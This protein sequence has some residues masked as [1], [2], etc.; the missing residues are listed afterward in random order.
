MTLQKTK[1]K[2]P[3][4]LPNNQP[5]RLNHHRTTLI[6]AMTSQPLRKLLLQ[7]RKTIHLVMTLMTAIVTRN[8]H[9]RRRLLPRK[10][11][12]LIRLMT[13]NLKKSQPN[14]QEQTQ[15]LKKLTLQLKRGQELTLRLS[16]KK[17][18]QSQRSPL[19]A[20]QN[21][22]SKVS[23]TIRLKTHLEDILSSSVL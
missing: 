18:Q 1:N 17:P 2:Q 7:Q 12:H 5:R 19:M 11:I 20:Q 10:L 14:D 9:Q 4:Q 6:P 23:P 13:Q 3:N 22:L 21:Y 15:R 8:Q 16:K